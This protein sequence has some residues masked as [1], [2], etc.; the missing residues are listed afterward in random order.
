M[1]PGMIKIHALEHFLEHITNTSKF[2]NVIEAIKGNLKK[3]QLELF[4]KDIFNHFV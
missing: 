3:R 2:R 4:K 1:E